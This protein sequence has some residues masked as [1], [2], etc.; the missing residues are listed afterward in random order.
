[1]IGICCDELSDGAPRVQAL[2]YFYLNRALMP[3]DRTHNFNASFVAE[4]PFGAGKRYLT[5]RA[6]S[7]IAGGWQVN[8]LLSLYSGSPFTVTA[9]DTLSLPGSNQRADQV[10]P[11][12]KIF[13]DPV[14]V[15][16]PD[17][18]R[19]RDRSALRHGRIQ[20]PARSRYAELRFQYLPDV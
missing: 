10:K 16:R 3:Y 11:E 13:G 19:S 5:G 1:M 8:G 20:L 14:I 9:S 7:A 18:L 4:L 17:G 6:A 15:L 2:N 12:V